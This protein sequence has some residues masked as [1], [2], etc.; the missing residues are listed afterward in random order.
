MYVVAIKYTLYVLV[1]TRVINYSYTVMTYDYVRKKG[2]N[3]E[4]QRH[5]IQNIEINL[6]RSFVNNHLPAE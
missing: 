1:C 2:L 4:Q 3:I 5:Y 6:W